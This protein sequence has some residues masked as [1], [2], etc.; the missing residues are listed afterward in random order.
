MNGKLVTKEIDYQQNG[1]R[2]AGYLAYDDSVSNPRPGILLVH[3]WWGL[4][5]NIRRKADD[6][7]RLGYVAFA[8]DMY[9]KGVVTNDPKEASRL[10]GG[11]YGNPLMAER[12]NAGLQELLKTGLADPEKIAAI[13]FCFGGSTVQRLAYSGAALRGI[14]S[15]HGGLEIP[16]AE[17]AARDKAKILI[18][19][20]AKDP[21]TPTDKMMDY[22]NAM[23]KTNL[24][25][26]M[27][28]YS[29]AKHAFTNPKADS[30]GLDSIAYNAVAARR[31]WEQMQ[32]FFTEI[33]K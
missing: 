3:E 17:D 12:A 1:T 19:H 15:F 27:V 2:L 20:G 16:S 5:D 33:F 4:T 28:L 25:W 10:A 26:E 9:G 18:L 24:D 7:A 21:V 29:G 11:F 32:A 22:L 23:N 8:A 13:G 6:L 31:S 14:V 30:Y